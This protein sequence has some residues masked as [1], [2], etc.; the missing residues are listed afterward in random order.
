MIRASSFRVIEAFSFP[1]QRGKRSKGQRW[2]KVSSPFQSFDPLI[3]CPF[4]LR[5]LL[6][7]LVYFLGATGFEEGLALLYSFMKSSVISAPSA[8]QARRLLFSATSRSSTRT[9][10]RSWLYWPRKL[11]I[12]IAT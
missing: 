12:L 4:A 7:W 9:I 2:E 3:F 6:N 5:K 11:L 1:A 10:L 8:T